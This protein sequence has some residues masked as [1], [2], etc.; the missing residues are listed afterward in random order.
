MFFRIENFIPAPSLE[1]IL[2]QITA[3]TW[4]DGKRTA[5]A[6]KNRKDNEQLTP[7]TGA[8]RPVLM[9]MNQFVMRHPAI[10]KWAEPRRVGRIMF[11]R[12][13]AGNFYASHNDAAIIRGQAGPIRADIS[14]T[15]FLNDPD[16]YEGGELVLESALGEKSLK[17][18]AGTIV[19]YDTGFRHRVEEI[20]SGQRIVAVG[21]LESLMRSPE[22]RE[23]AR[24]LR[25]IIGHVSENLGT[26]HEDVI[27]LR[28]VFANFSRYVAET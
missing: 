11:S 15:V 23:I 27:A 4:E 12:Y 5:A 3:M 16:D 21:W 8:A 17:E 26:D 20:T 24:E 13:G 22:A 18:P 7:A 9:Q 6:G 1:E 10:Q 2:D 14:F 28:R 25:T 19:L